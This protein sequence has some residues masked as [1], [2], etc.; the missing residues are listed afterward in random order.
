MKQLV[1]F[2]GLSID[3]TIYPTDIDGIVE[4]K[5]SEYIILEIKYGHADVPYGQKLALQ[6]MV[7]DFTTVGKQAVAF[8][9]EHNVEDVNTPIVAA[10]CKVREIYYGGEK[11]WRAPDERI[12]VREAVDIFQNY[13]KSITEKKNRS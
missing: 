5:D 8:I 11:K 7:D 1:D 6:R 13:S 12:T 2:G 3:G 4:Y 10:Q 9:C